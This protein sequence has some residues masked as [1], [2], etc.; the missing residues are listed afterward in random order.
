MKYLLSLIL[1]LILAACAGG[2]TTPKVETPLVPALPNSNP[3][4][5][6]ASNN[7]AIL[8]GA[9]IGSNVASVDNLR[10]T[11]TVLL[12]EDTKGI[13]F[14]NA[15][16]TR[17]SVSNETLYW[18]MEFRNTSSTTA[19]FIQFNNIRLKD[20]A[21]TRLLSK[22][23]SF[24]YGSVGHNSSKT[25]YTS[26]CLAPNQHGFL[27][28]IEIAD[29]VPNVYSRTSQIEISK[30]EIT[31]TL[32]PAPQKVSPITY[33]VE[34]ARSLSRLDVTVK[35]ESQDAFELGASLYVLL[36]DD[37]KGLEW[38]YLLKDED[39]A[40]AAGATSLIDGLSLYQGTSKKVWVSVDFDLPKTNL[41]N[42][43]TIEKLELRDQLELAKLETLE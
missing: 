38:G 11:L 20:S 26:T 33:T 8:I 25:I 18:L 30:I 9:E 13:E 23:R 29:S 5:R 22:N 2:N 39:T 10:K 37:N 34:N 31:T 1:V 28:G 42:L 36:D 21:G 24:I 14:I 12:P 3:G 32:E 7:S 17:N 6:A 41:N 43:G 40:V 16:A 19:C 35:N 15:Y 4:E 27:I